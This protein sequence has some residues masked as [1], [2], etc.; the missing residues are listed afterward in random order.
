MKRDPSQLILPAGC[1]D[2]PVKTKAVILFLEYVAP[3]D[4]LR[5][6]TGG[7]AAGLG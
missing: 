3:Q 2:L 6:A 5:G 4:I 1:Q 7:A